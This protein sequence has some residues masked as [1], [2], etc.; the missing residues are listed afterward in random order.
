[1]KPL[2]RSFHSCCIY[3]EESTN[4]AA[5]KAHADRGSTV[6]DAAVGISA[7]ERQFVRKEIGA[8]WGKLSEHHVSGLKD[9]DDLVRELLPATVSK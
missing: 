3:L 5:S 8:R 9:R 2:K 1:L 4:K 7:V 6:P